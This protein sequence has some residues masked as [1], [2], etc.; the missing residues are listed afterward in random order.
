MRLEAAEAR[1]VGEVASPSL[2]ETLVAGDLDGLA[3]IDD[4]RGAA[5]YRRDVALTL[6]RRAVSGML[7]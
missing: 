5:A 2:A 3:P 1:L 6:V 7:G 4:V